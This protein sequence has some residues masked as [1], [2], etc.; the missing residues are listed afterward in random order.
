MSICG[1]CEERLRESR[2]RR[3]C[4]ECLE[5]WSVNEEK[6]GKCFGVSEYE[7][8]AEIVTQEPEPQVAFA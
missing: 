8:R 4:P 1:T 2:F 3:F 6:K 5:R 7:E